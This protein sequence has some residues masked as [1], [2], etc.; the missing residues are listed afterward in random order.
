MTTAFLPKHEDIRIAEALHLL[1]PPAGYDLWHGGPPIIQC[2]KDVGS[3]QATWS[4]TPKSRSV[5]HFVLH[6]SYWKFRVRQQVTG[7]SSNTFPRHP[8]NFP[9]VPSVITETAWKA[10]VALLKKENTLLIEAV[11]QLHPDDVDRPFPS[12]NRLYDQ[13]MGI[14]LH[15]AYHVAQIQLLKRLYEELHP[16]TLAGPAS[17]TS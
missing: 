6:L 16:E 13:I 10:D 4:V 7:I 1:D 2:L 5:W 3:E 14:A 15:D 8:E 11:K 17:T 9:D 12:G